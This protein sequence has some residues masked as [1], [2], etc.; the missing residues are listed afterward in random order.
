[1]KY[2][3]FSKLPLWVTGLAF[4]SSLTS[5]AAFS[6]Y[7]SPPDVEKAEDSGLIGGSISTENFNS[8]PTGA[9]GTFPV[10]GAYISPTIGATYTYGG[11]PTSGAGAQILGNNVFGGNGEGN[12][13]GV[14]TSSSVTISLD[15]SIYVDGAQYFGIY[16][17]ASDVNNTISFYQDDALVFSFSNATLLAMIPKNLTLTAIDGSTYNTKTTITVNR[18]QT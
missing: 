6:V 2:I 3:Y 12:Y 4:A 10:N 11:G 15:S 17:T 5:D 14:S 8:L 13:L 7:L 16:L 18:A 1:M 9:N